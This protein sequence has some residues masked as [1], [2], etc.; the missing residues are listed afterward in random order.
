MWIIWIAHKDLV[1]QTTPK[2]IHKDIAQRDATIAHDDKRWQDGRHILK[3]QDQPEAEISL[4][5]IEQD[6]TTTPPLVGKLATPANLLEKD[7]KQTWFPKLQGKKSWITDTHKAFQTMRQ[8][9]M[10]RFVPSYDPQ[11]HTPTPTVTCKDKEQATI[12]IGL[13]SAAGFHLN[14]QDWG[15]TIFS[16]MLNEIDHKIHDQK[17]WDDATKATNNELVACKLLQEYT[18]MVDVLSQMD[19]DELPLHWDID[20]KIIL[21]Q[22]NSLE[23]SPLYRM[24][25]AELQAVKQYLLDNLSKGFIAPS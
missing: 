19:S 15:A 8:V 22:E 2:A 18:D 11:V 12:D 20:H 6:D 7:E 1:H 9:L 17:A 3:W 14:C 24:S 25:I 21:T 23:L 5:P 16:I 4:A 13:I 10:D